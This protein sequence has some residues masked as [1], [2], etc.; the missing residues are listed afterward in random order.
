[1]D[2]VVVEVSEW[3]QSTDV[4]ERRNVEQEVN[5]VREHSIFRCLIKETTAVL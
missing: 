3:D 2:G 4:D 5:D 1:M